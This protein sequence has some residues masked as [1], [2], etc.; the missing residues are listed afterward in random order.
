VQFTP[1]ILLPFVAPRQMIPFP[2]SA[3]GRLMTVYHA[4]PSS[5]RCPRFITEVPPTGNLHVKKCEGPS[6]STAPPAAGPVL[7]IASTRMHPH[8]RLWASK[9]VLHQSAHAPQSIAHSVA[10]DSQKGGQTPQ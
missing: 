7:L 3:A 2:D 1:E 5:S 4:G 6:N 9:V 8:V 10:A